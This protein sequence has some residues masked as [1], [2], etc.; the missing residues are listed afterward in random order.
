VWLV[1]IKIRSFDCN[2]RR[3]EILA[4]IKAAIIAANTQNNYSLQSHHSH[5][6]FLV[7]L[8]NVAKEFSL[9]IFF[10]V[11]N[12]VNRWGYNSS[13]KKGKNINNTVLGGPVI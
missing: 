8:N 5:H 12:I 3:T 9:S 4:A 7:G 1:T 11:V 13:A 6:L 2:S 10:K